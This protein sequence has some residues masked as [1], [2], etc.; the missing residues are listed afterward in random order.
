MYVNPRSVSLPRVL[1]LVLDGA[2]MP[3]PRPGCIVD[4]DVDGLLGDVSRSRQLKR[5]DDLKMRRLRH[6]FEPPACFVDSLQHGWLGVKDRSAQAARSLDPEM[7]SVEG[8]CRPWRTRPDLRGSGGL[9]LCIETLA[10]ARRRI[11]PPALPSARCSMR[12]AQ[13]FIYEL[14]LK[15][16][17]IQHKGTKYRGDISLGKATIGVRWERLVDHLM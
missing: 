14:G 6:M 5:E 12:I 16:P 8:A 4:W 1:P 15:T 11:A 10:L 7:L 9:G 17:V 2:D 13:L 3:H